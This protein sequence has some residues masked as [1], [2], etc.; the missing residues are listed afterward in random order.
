MIKEFKEF[1]MRGNVID[2]AIGI[3]IGIAFGAVINS[4]VND[5][6]M[7][8]IGLL[9]GKVNFANLFVV[10]RQG[11]TPP[12]YNTVEAAN[13]AGAVTL[14]Y[15]LFINTVISFIIIALVVFGIVK[16]MNGLRKKE[17]VKPVEVKECPYCYS[18]IN[19]KATRCPNC[20][21]ELK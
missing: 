17:E 15:G 18:S 20:T 14:N 6:I 21:S 7:P 16:L 8:P 12:P 13:E 4:V 2:M 19:I 3:V 9:L 5:I 1:I 10:L 11:I